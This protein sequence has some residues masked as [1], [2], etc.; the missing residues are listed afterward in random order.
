MN[1]YVTMNVTPSTSSLFGAVAIE[2]GLIPKPGEYHITI[3]YLTRWRRAP[4]VF[5]NPNR[6]VAATITG[7]QVIETRKVG[8]RP[9]SRLLVAR[10]E[11]QGHPSF[12]GD[13]IF[14]YRNRQI[15]HETEGVTDHKFMAHVTLGT[16]PDGRVPDLSGLQQKVGTSIS[17]TGVEI[18]NTYVLRF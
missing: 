16:I 14:R 17:F 8:C 7:F 10:V 3:A 13:D 9:G 12:G 5:A 11:G 15:L 1:Y 18:L 6:P 4:T 2:N